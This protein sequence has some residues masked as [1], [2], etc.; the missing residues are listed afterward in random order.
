MNLYVSIAYLIVYMLSTLMY[1]LFG[2]EIVVIS[3]LA[4]LFAFNFGGDKL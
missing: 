1:Y 4:W 3:L 2:F